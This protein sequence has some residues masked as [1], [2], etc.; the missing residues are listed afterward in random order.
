MSRYRFPSL[1]KGKYSE[2]ARY[3]NT[4]MNDTGCCLCRICQI[5]PD[6]QTGTSLSSFLVTLGNEPQD[7]SKNTTIYKIYCLPMGAEGLFDES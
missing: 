6:F 3:S 5:K 1:C 7:G 2:L 4:S